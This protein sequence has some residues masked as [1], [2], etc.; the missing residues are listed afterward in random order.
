MYIVPQIIYANKMRYIDADKL[1]AE[2][3]RQQRKFIV[4]SSYTRQ[5]DTKRDYAL[6]NGAYKHILGII[7]SLLQ[8]Q[9]GV[10]LDKELDNFITEHDDWDDDNKLARDI[11]RHFYERGLN[12]R[13]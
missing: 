7:N 12:A 8:E 1:I 13:K 2:I 6:L 3:E 10:D 5:I 11:A 4:L 9:Q